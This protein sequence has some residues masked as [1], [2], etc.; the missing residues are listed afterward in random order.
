METASK[1]LMNFVRNLANVLDYWF[2][3]TIHVFRKQKT[4][5]EV[6]RIL[7]VERLSVGDMVS[8]TPVLRALHERF[9]K[10]KIDILVNP[11][12]KDLIETL[13]YLNKVYNFSDKELKSNYKQIVHEYKNNNYD[14]GVIIR[15]GTYQISKLL[16]DSKVK[17]RIGSAKAGLLVGRGFFLHRKAKA[18]LKTRHVVDLNLDVIR[19]I[20]INPK[21]PKTEL[22]IQ[23]EVKNQVTKKLN[24][25]KK[26]FVIGIHPGSKGI[27]SIKHPSHLWPVER[28][29]YV[30]D[31]LSKKYKAKIVFSGAKNEL[32]L[33]KKIES[34][35]KTK[36]IIATDLNM[37]EFVS[38]IDRMDMLFSN[39]TA[40]AH[41]AA[42]LDTPLV[43]IFG[44]QT[45]KLWKPW[46]DKVIVLYKNNKCTAC[47]RYECKL[48]T[49]ECLK[50][51]S[52]TEVLN[53]LEKA[54]EWVR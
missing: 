16:K 23:D 28:Y 42:A 5:P 25:N 19:T 34:L 52:P 53:A 39:D 32:P 1:Q 33:I 29:A 40:A 11:H 47:Q 7:V 3:E 17:F 31:Q 54:K 20:G 27:C 13:P 6:K 15:H 2:Y 18:Y 4:L 44:P 14:L 38:L 35:M 24:L 21:N 26:D 50:A 36:P 10:A 49:V 46:N 37:K 48:K 9:P 22:K 45:P 8:V 12:I 51:I 30:A 43:I 41:V